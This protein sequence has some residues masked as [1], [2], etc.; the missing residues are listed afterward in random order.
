MKQAVTGRGEVRHTRVVVIGAGFAGLGMAAGLT[1]AGHDDF[2]VLE[3]AED[4]GGTWRENTYPGCE[5]DVP[6]ALYSYSFEQQAW[7]GVRASQPEI[8]R[9]LRKVSVKYGLR[10]KIEFGVEV[11]R[12]HWDEVDGRWH[13][14]TTTGLEFV[15]QY[16]VVGT[17]ALHLPKVPKTPGAASFGGPAFHSARWDHSVDLTGKR[18]AVIGT[19]ASAIQM[20]PEL[21]AVAGSVQLY[22][23]TPPWV[24]PRR[25]AGRL[26]RAVGRVPVLRGLVRSLTYWNAELLAIGL[27]GRPALT[28]PMEWRAERHLRRQI[29]DPALRA[30]LTPDYRIGCK[31]ILRSDNYFPAVARP[32]TELIADRIAEITPDGIVTADGTTRAADVIVYATG[33]RVA[34]SLARL[35]LAGRDG[36]TLQ[37]RWMRDGIRTHLG[38]SVS[39]LPNAFFLTGPNTGLGHNSVVFMIESQVRYALR[40]MELVDRERVSALDVRADAQAAFHDDLHARLGTAVWSTGGCS[41]WYV[42]ANGT[43]HSVWPGFSWQYWL[44]TRRVSRR[45]HHLL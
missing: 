16:L 43:N 30:K 17:G 24:L 14:F 4:V 40:A 36:V 13:L 45:D 2:I 11:E 26:T 34:G 5:C 31:R 21:A 12:G 25:E 7:G 20:V 37:E 32:G 28:R 29:P 33:F 10:D 18:V 42:D 41:S 22:Q 38:I 6:S 35:P 23:R 44:R 1:R 39:G 9:Y 19:G 15:A 3:K 27:N 8:L